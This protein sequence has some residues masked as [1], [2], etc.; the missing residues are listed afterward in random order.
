MIDRNAE[1]LRNKIEVLE[2]RKAELLR[3]IA[4]KQA[5]VDRM[6]A[7]FSPGSAGG[8]AAGAG[9]RDRDRHGQTGPVSTGFKYGLVVSLVIGIIFVVFA[10]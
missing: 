5:E 2:R 3:Q 1:I 10:K 6:Q 7:L 8:G 9:R 4:D